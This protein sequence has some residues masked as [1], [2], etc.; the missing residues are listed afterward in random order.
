MYEY[1]FILTDRSVCSS[2]AY[3]IGGFGVARD[4]FNRING[5][6]DSFCINIIDLM[7]EPDLIFC[8][9]CDVELAMSRI[10]KKDSFEKLD[11]SFFTKIRNYYI[12][13]ANKDNFYLIDQLDIDLTVKLL[14]SYTVDYFMLNPM[15]KII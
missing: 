10:E 14:L 9:D 5:G 11:K 1:D 7:P 3:S 2:E 8:I 13:M 15:K 6:D 4:F 12:S